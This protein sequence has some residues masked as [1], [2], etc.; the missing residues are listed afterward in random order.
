M[1]KVNKEFEFELSA[2]DRGY[3]FSSICYYACAYLITFILEILIVSTKLYIYAL[4][5]YSWIDT[6]VG[7]LLV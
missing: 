4:Y 6:S 2:I 7:E 3:K 1:F 5:Y